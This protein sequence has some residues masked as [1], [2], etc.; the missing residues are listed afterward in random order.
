MNK[1]KTK[2]AEKLY[3]NGETEKLTKL[4]LPCIELKDPFAINLFSVFSQ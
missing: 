4:L 2:L 3:D 1:S